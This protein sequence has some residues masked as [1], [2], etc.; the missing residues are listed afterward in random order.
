MQL[1]AFLNTDNI[2][3]QVIEGRAIG[4]VVNGISDWETHYTESFGLLCKSVDM[5]K[6][7]GYPSIGYYYNATTNEFQSKDVTNEAD[8][9]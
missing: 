7:T 3:V 9:V 6:V 5:S 8:P 2:V 4:E 1:Y